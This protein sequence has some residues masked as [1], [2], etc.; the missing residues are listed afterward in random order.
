MSAIEW[1]WRIV[2]VDDGDEGKQAAVQHEWWDFSESSFNKQYCFNPIL[3]RD[4]SSET[5]PVQVAPAEKQVEAAL[6]DLGT[7]TITESDKHSGNQV[8]IRL[9]VESGV[10]SVPPVVTNVIGQAVINSI[11]ASENITGDDIYPLASS[12]LESFNSM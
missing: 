7:G 11:V 5:D 8:D 12:L 1:V 3:L 6:D 2:K 4:P 9:G 10:Q